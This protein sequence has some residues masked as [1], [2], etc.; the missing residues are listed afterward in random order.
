MS[1]LLTLS[2]DVKIANDNLDITTS[3]GTINTY[4][5]DYGV[6]Q[7]SNY[8]RYGNIVCISFEFHQT[9]NIPTWATVKIADGL[10]KPTATRRICG[11]IVDGIDIMTFVEIGTDGILTLY[12]RNNADI[13]ANYQIRYYGLCYII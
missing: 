12:N 2:N 11:G 13:P 3:S 4:T 5:N 1:K 6:V 10:P 8:A 7:N 9:K